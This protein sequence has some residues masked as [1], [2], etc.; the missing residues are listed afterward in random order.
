[1][2]PDQSKRRPLH[3]G[4]AV[5][6]VEDISPVESHATI[7]YRVYLFWEFKEPRLRPF[8]DRARAKGGRLTLGNG[9]GGGGG[10]D[11]GVVDEVSELSHSTT[12]P[13]V[14]V[15]NKVEEPVCMDPATFRIYAPSL[16]GSG[17][18]G[19]R[20]GGGEDSEEEG[21]VGRGWVMWNAQHSCK[22]KCPFRLETFPFDSQELRLDLK[23]LQVSGDISSRGPR[24]IRTLHSFVRSFVRSFVSALQACFRLI[25]SW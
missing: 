25:A 20:P 3:C 24:W 13:V 10:G 6:A 17:G 23:L 1:M 12:V 5:Y 9:D 14:E 18:D 7:V 15:Y 8:L 4:V 22:I 2:A 21:A 19:P 11:G 16:R